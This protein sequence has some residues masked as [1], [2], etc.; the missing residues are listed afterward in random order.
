MAVETFEGGTVITG[1]RDTAIF[2]LMA[3]RRAVIAES[4]GR[5][6]TRIKVTPLWR[7]HLGLKPR[8]SHADVVAGIEAQIEELSRGR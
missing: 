6:L 2:G 1:P 5:Q 3:A 4:E 8:A 7:K